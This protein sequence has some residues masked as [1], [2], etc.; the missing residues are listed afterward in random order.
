[1]LQIPR[2]VSRDDETAGLAQAADTDGVVDLAVRAKQ[3]FDGLS[4]SERR[5]LPLLAEPERW[6]AVPGIGP[7]VAKATGL[8]LI[9][10]VR[11]ATVD[12][13]DRDAVVL[14]LVRL[15]SRPDGG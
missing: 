7:E 2:F 11:L 6:E 10:T 5:L 1:L 3:I 13:A 12:D 4:E 8:A 15:C 14:E 9:E